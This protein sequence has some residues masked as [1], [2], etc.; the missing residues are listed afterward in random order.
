[1]YPI[2]F[3]LGPITIQTVS[4]LHAL[5]FYVG[6]FLVIKYAKEYKFDKEKMYELI[7]VI[8]ISSV[9]GARVFSILFDGSLDYYLKNP[10]AMLMVWNGGFTFYGGF[11]F[12]VIT[13]LWYI[14]KQNLDLWRVTDLFAPALA[15]GLAVG[16]LGCLAS[17]DSYGKPTDLPWA[18][19]YTDKHSMAP[20]GVYLHPTQIYSVITN[21]IIFGLLIWMKKR[22]KFKGEIFVLFLIFYSIT[23]SFVE[24]FRDDPRGVYLNGLISTSQIIS[25]I[26]ILTGMVLY[27]F[28]KKKYTVSGDVH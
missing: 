1:M 4:I 16:R 26:V 7:I 11:V 15:L 25:I 12:S 28:L 20:L 13:G 23:R 8:T 24:I 10:A 9:V 18:V 22:Q 19:L 5:G 2:L 17:G 21:L 6:I 3:K 14:K 27:G